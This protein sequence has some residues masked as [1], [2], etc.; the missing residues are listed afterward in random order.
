MVASAR[1][2]SSAKRDRK[3][4]RTSDDGEED[5]YTIGSD[6]DFDVSEVEEEEDVATTSEDDI[7]DEVEVS[8]EEPAVATKSGKKSEQPKYKSPPSPCGLKIHP[9][10]GDLPPISNL[11]DM[12]DDMVS[13][14]PDVKG[15]FGSGGYRKLRVATMCSGTE[16]PLLAL[17]MI[18]GSLKKFGLGHLEIDHVFSCEI[19]PF[20]QA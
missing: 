9:R 20:K 16:S 8:E 5:E 1:T 6:G 2:S 3:P 18:S 7:V 12:F 14:L 15:L 19:E 17:G 4:K 11:K 13:R 10:D